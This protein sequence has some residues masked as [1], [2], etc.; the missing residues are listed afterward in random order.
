VALGIVSP[1]L[2]LLADYFGLLGA[3]DWDR[4]PGAAL[5]TLPALVA[6]WGVHPFVAL[7]SLRGRPEDPALALWRTALGLGPFT[8][9]AAVAAFTLEDERFALLFGWL[10]FVGWAG[11]AMHALMVRVV[12]FLAEPARSTAQGTSPW[13]AAR[14]PDAWT[15]SSLALHLTTLVVGGVAIV[16][17]RDVLTRIAGLALMALGVVL[18]ASY[19]RALRRPVVSDPGKSG[20]ASR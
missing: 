13:T 16:T 3:G 12:P 10:A 8:L 2:W 19:L 11:F 9:L 17:R 6:V 4:A 15:W 14:I 5:L 1:V 20:G 7:S 18:L